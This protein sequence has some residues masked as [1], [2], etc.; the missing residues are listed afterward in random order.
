[1]TT[2]WTLNL[3][4]LF[5]VTLCGSCLIS[6]VDADQDWTK[7][8]HDLCSRLSVTEK[9]SQL[10]T[11]AAAVPQEQGFAA[12]N[13]WSEALHGINNQQGGGTIFPQPLGLAATFN[14]ALLRHVAD[15]I[16]TEARAFNNRQIAAGGDPRFLNVFSPNINIFRDPRWGRGSETY[17]EDPY[18]T[19]QLGVEYVKG[20]QG[21]DSTYLKISATCKHFAAY[22][23]EQ[24]DGITR[25]AFDAQ[26]S[27]KDLQET[28]LPAF[29]ACVREGQAASV[30]CSYNAVNGVPACANPDLLQ[31]TLREQW[32]FGGFVV[33]D[34]GAV[35]ATWWPH[36]LTEEEAE[37]Q[38]KCLKAGCDMSCTDYGKLKEALEQKLVDE[39]EI[40]RALVRSLTI[41][42]RL[43]MFDPSDAV[44]YSTIPPS[45][46]GTQ[47][48]IEAATEAARQ[49]IVLLKNDKEGADGHAL[50][51]TA[52]SLTKVIVV[53]QPA[54]QTELLFGN[55]YGKPAGKVT[56]PLEAV[57]AVV[58]ADKVAWQP[59]PHIVAGN[60]EGSIDDVVRAAEDADVVLF[61]A[62]ITM[63]NERECKATDQAPAWVP[64][65]EGEG[66]DRHDL[67][68]PASQLDTLQGLAART[69]AKI[70]VILIHGGPLAIEWLQASPK[71]TAILTAWMPG[72]GA[73]AIA[74]VLFGKV[75]PSGR[76]PVTFYHANYTQLVKSASMD[77]AVWPGRTHRYLQE[78]ALYPFG[79]GLSYTAFEYGSPQLIPARMRRNDM[80]LIE[81]SIC[82]T[83]GMAADEVVLL[84]MSPQET[85]TRKLNTLNLPKQSLRDFERIHLQSGEHSSLQMK[86][87]LEHFSH[88][89]TDSLG[90]TSVQ[91]I[92]GLWKVQIGAQ[93]ILLWLGPEGLSVAQPEGGQLQMT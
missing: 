15:I 22:S 7:R 66:L 37:S 29:E 69:D 44:P 58:G 55:Y 49:S 60:A 81:V 90:R 46:I 4:L 12:F 17:G 23:L 52:S 51:L 70:V 80:A 47:D 54:V 74:D 9:L 38:A 36:K 1:M 64:F 3:K 14:R 6:P 91:A 85:A 86:L 41:R 87:P 57:Q 19:S 13:W 28:Y 53:G 78:P 62:G 21:N 39:S 30:M 42:L 5:A 68:L 59:G 82:N 20:L 25:K 63:L 35:Q 83:G 73:G 11:P 18:L 31:T 93:S 65:L 26:V 84:I 92:H 71:V 48:H 33:S 75:S 43:G 40:D 76:L 77:M 16:S 2:E 79:Y 10:N 32:G 45:M 89:V 88:A 50:P 34:C 27:D 67:N 56:S 8:A 61:F 72:Q 24:E